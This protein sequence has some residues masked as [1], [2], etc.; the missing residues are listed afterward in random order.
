MLWEKISSIPKNT[1]T[2]TAKNCRHLPTPCKNFAIVSLEHTEKHIY[3]NCI[4][5]NTHF[6]PTIY[7]LAGKMCN[8]THIMCNLHKSWSTRGH[9]DQGSQIHKLYLHKSQNHLK[10]PHP[11]H[12]TFMS[13]HFLSKFR[14]K[15]RHIISANGV[16]KCK[17]YICKIVFLGA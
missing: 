2:H 5:T 4:C 12:H 14:K 1:L 11:I 10:Q 9:V 15:F 8:F 16:R 7:V 17:C 3:T 6:W 13:F